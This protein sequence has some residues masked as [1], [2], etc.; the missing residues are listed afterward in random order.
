[1]KTSLLL[2]QKLRIYLCIILIF[3]LT[4]ISNSGF[5]Q[6]PQSFT[7]SGTFVVPAGVTSLTVEAWG[8]GGGGGGT[9][10][11]LDAANGVGKP[12]GRNLFKKFK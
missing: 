6:T 9:K 4:I 1:M 12:I 8:S 11:P 10:R 2:S 7:S 5:G 3:A